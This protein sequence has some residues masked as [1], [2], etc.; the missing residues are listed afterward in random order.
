MKIKVMKEIEVEIE[1]VVIE[2][3]PRYLDEKESAFHKSKDTPMFDGK[4]VSIAFNPE[5]G[6][7]FGWPHNK[8]VSIYEKICDEGTYILL[9]ED[10]NEVA[11][12]RENYVPS[13]VPNEFGDYIVLEIDDGGT[14]TNFIPN[15]DFS[16][17]FEKED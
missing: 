16:E 11:A 12:I 13:V 7:I 2:F 14:I 5:T 6:G 17:F 1:K 8:P 3:S 10:D 4:Q 9:D 15:P